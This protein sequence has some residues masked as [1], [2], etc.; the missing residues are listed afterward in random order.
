[1]GKAEPGGGERGRYGPE[2][3]TLAD[4]DAVLG[5]VPQRRHGLGHE[6]VAPVQWS[7]PFAVRRATYSIQRSRTFFPGAIWGTSF[8]RTSARAWPAEVYF[9]RLQGSAG[10]GGRGGAKRGGPTRRRRG[11]SGPA[12]LSAAP[13]AS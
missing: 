6:F 7:A 8:L 9:V 12:S 1:M 2:R 13:A 3:L 5:L 10:A 11:P 4:L